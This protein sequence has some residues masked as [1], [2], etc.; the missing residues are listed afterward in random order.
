MKFQVI[1]KR[2]GYYNHLRRKEE[3]KFEMSYEGLTKAEKILDKANKTFIKYAG[4]EYFIPTWV[5]VIGPVDL[6]S[7]DEAG[8]QVS[9]KKKSVQKEVKKDDLEVAESTFSQDVI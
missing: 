1:A 9:T 5:K 8:F 4:Q 3:S 6:V 2:T 7:Y